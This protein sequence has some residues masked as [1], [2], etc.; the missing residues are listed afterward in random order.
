[1]RDMPASTAA[2]RNELNFRTACPSRMLVLSSNGSA[3]STSVITPAA[4]AEIV[5]WADRYSGNGGVGIAGSQVES[6]ASRMNVRGRI[7]L[8]RNL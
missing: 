3:P 5:E 4:A 7:R 2:S 1:M 8:S 6:I